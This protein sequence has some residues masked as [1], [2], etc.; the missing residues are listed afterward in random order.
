[1]RTS[2]WSRIN[3]LYAKDDDRDHSRG[4]FCGPFQ[5]RTK[6]KAWTLTT[7]GYQWIITYCSISTFRWHVVPVIRSLGVIS[8]GH[9]QHI[10][11]TTLDF[12]RLWD[13]ASHVW[14]EADCFSGG[15]WTNLEKTVPLGPAESHFFAF[16]FIPLDLLSRKE[17][18][19]DSTMLRDLLSHFL[20][21]CF[22]FLLTV[23]FALI[24]NVCVVP[25]SDLNHRGGMFTRDPQFRLA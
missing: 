8:R 15:R 5:F 6:N 19:P 18:D 13:A 16:N 22:L 17:G 9:S 11:G 10:Y 3:L 14:F 25:S 24:F 4:H 7:A 20:D 12:G 2:R 1:M 21:F 23:M